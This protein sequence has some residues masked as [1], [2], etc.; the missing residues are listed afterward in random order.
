M[1]GLAGQ[2]ARGHA[3]EEDRGVGGGAL[4]VLRCQG[5]EKNS[6]MVQAQLQPTRTRIEKWN[7]AIE[8]SVHAFIAIC[9]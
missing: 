4:P 8:P 9:I 5:L 2:V 7:F 1:S 3:R 6:G